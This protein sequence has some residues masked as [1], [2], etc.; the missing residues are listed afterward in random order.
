[1]AA[2]IVDF[3]YLAGHPMSFVPRNADKG[4]NRPAL[5]R[6]SRNTPKPQSSV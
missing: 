2:A 6:R 5:R 3:G 1:M 4:Q